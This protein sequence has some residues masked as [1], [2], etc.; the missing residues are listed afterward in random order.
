MRSIMNLNFGWK[1]KESFEDAFVENGFDDS[2]FAD[3]MLPH[4]NIEL[5]YNNFNEKCIQFISCYRKK[6][7]VTGE[8][9][10]ERAI[11]HFDGVMAYCR[12]YLNGSYAGE[13]KG[14]YTPFRL[15]VTGFIR[16]DGENVLVVMVDSTEREDIPPFGHVIDYLTY[17]GIYREVS[18]VFV[19]E[20]H[21]DNLHIRT[22]DVLT[23]NMKM[24]IDLHLENHSGAEKAIVIEFELLCRD[25]SKLKFME[26]GVTLAPG[27]SKLTFTKAL[28]QKMELW[29]LQ[30]PN[31]YHVAVKVLHDGV[32]LDECK[33]R[34]GF[35]EA[36]FQKDGFHLN[37]KRIKLRG[38]NRHQSFPYVGYAMPKGAQ[39]KDAEILKLD[40]GVNLVR[41]SHY[42]QSRHFLDRCDELGLLVFEEMPG[43]QHIGD[44]AWQDVAVQN[45]EDMIKRDWN[46]PCVILWGVRINESAD[47]DR[48]YA[49]TNRVA[50]ELDPDRQTGGVRNFG[51]SRLLEDVYTYNDFVHDGLNDALQPRS[52]IVKTDAPYLVTEH[53]GHMFPTKKYDNESRRIE[54]ALRHLRVMDKMYRAADISGA[55][56]WCMSDYN[57]HRDFGSGDRIC[58]HGVLDM[59]RIPKEAAWAYSSQQEGSPVMEVAA[60]MVPGE[61]DGG[62]LREAIV[63]T[64]CDSVRLSKNGTYVG[65]YGPDRE[66]Y[67]GIPHPP[68]VITDFIGDLIE[69]NEGFAK[70]DAMLAKEIL[71]AV[72]RHG[73]QSLPM[74]Y[75]LKMAYLMFKCHL[76]HAKAVALYTTYVANWGGKSPVY[77]FT[78]FVSDKPVGT[79][80]KG[81]ADSAGLFA[82]ADKDRL[83]EEETYDVCRI[84]LKHLDS[85]GNVMTLSNEVITLETEGPGEVIGPGQIALIGGSIAFWVKTAGKSGTL[86]VRVRS[87]RFG[88]Q[89]LSFAVEKR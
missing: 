63:F 24:E 17:G 67:P 5:P 87:G 42:P 44:E 30:A 77:E 12:V 9:A 1:Y 69:K 14:G 39:Y 48:F 34:F 58:Y 45:V 55:I 75:K 7:P 81:P 46:R 11:L 40:L 19:Q 2:G 10:G 32:L 84:V 47:D 29:D 83:V 8:Q 43:W 23:E 51:G 57:T 88:D 18:L 66:A 62:V 22:K 76:S 52:R 15:D 68:V 53:N 59:F 33:E 41:L 27:P 85:L 35:R 26:G 54:Q 37:G 3:V 49:R 72:V 4:A 71:Q 21:V 56:G 36:V 20:I 31:L 61:R 86:Q 60:S 64:N 70:N 65:T 74:K 16:E 79:S 89:T 82:V 38:L 13:H 25:E 6:F 73:D 80:R 28:V 50:K 78:G